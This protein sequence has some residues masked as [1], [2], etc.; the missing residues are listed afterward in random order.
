MSIGLN[1]IIQR[2]LALWKYLP[3]VNIESNGAQWA[4]NFGERVSKFLKFVCRAFEP[5]PL[6]T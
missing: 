6:Q 2:Q 1:G 4:I 5:N 3:I